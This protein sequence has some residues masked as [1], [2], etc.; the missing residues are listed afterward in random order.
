[1]TTIK[2]KSLAGDE[3]QPVLIAHL[4]SDDFFFTKRFP[5][6]T[7]S[8]REAHLRADPYVGAPNLDVEGELTLRG[9]TAN[10][11]FPATA[12]QIAPGVLIARAQFDLDRTRWNIIYGSSRFFEHLGMHLVFDAISIE[13]KIVANRW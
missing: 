7:F 5:K 11:G 2:N 13:L 6:A 3:L 9:I 8:I 12:S 4:Q 1:M 10:L